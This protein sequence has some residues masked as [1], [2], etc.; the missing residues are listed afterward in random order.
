MKDPAFE[1]RQDTLDALQ[2][3]VDNFQEGYRHNVAL[4]GNEYMGKTTVLKTFI[5]AARLKPII[6]VYVEIIP[7]EFTLFLRKTAA[8][9]LFGLLENQQLVSSRETLE[10]IAMRLKDKYPQTQTLITPFLDRIGREKPEVLFKDLFA[11]IETAVNESQKKCVIVFDEFQNLRH[12]GAKNICQEFGKKIMFLKNVLFVVA[13]SAKKEAQ[14]ILACDLSLLFGNF[15]TLELLP[16]SPAASG[17][18]I[19]DHFQDTVVGDDL[20]R[21][22]THFAG[23]QP[24]YLKNICEEAVRECNIAGTPQVNKELLIGAINR[25]LFEDSGPLYHKF[26]CALMQLSQARNKNDFASVLESVAVGKNRLKDLSSHLRRPQKELTQRLNRLIEAGLLSKNGSFYL[27]CDRLMSFWL[28]FV[29]FEKRHSLTPDLAEQRAHFRKNLENEI[30]SFIAASHKSLSSRILDLFNLFEGD[31]V[32][33]DRKKFRL[34]SFKELRVVHFEDKEL[35]LG[36]F[37]KTQQDLWLAAIKGDDIRE[38]DVRVFDQWANK[39]KEKSVQKIMIGLGDFERN[40]RLLAKESRIATWDISHV[41]CLLDMYGKPRI[42][43]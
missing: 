39:Y 22:L 18:F 33:F 32:H 36:I 25:L 30:E 28:K 9:L 5:V 41:N 19:R 8:S 14:D 21:F 13:S 20:L 3:R 2:K 35:S 29:Y 34:L 15:E 38:H 42:I 23:G 6:C 11:V 43:A 10:N 26:S 31:C 24:F 27:F 12:L 7:C 1:P 16:L 17:A 4:L 37:G 40:A